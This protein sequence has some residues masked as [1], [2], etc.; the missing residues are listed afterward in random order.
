MIKYKIP[1]LVFI[2]IKLILL[3]IK[4]FN[5]IIYDILIY[6]FIYDFVFNPLSS[7]YDFN[8]TSEFE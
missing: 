1:M 5:Y 8:K 7:N 3:I 6:Y 2:A 4:L